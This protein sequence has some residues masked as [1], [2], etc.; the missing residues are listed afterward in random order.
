MKVAV[1]EASLIPS[2]KDHLVEIIDCNGLDEITSDEPFS[3]DEDGRCPHN[4][5]C[6]DEMS[7]Y[8]DG[9]ASSRKYCVSMG[10]HNRRIGEE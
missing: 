8:Y 2:D 10:E 1:Y 4:S 3:F 7:A 6:S 9:Y 5:D